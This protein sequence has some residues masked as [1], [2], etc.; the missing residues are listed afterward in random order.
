[1]GKARKRVSQKKKQQHDDDAIMARA[2]AA[3]AASGFAWMRDFG[4]RPVHDYNTG[5]CLA[6]TAREYMDESEELR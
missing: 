5:M 2:M 4:D 3:H 1:M 6:R